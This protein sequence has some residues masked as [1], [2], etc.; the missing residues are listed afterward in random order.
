MCGYVRVCTVVVRDSYGSGAGF[1]REWCGIRTGES[2]DPRL[3]GLVIGTG[4]KQNLFKGN[5]RV[6]QNLL[7]VGSD[8][9]IKHP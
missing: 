9:A 2:R 5:G 4:L 7:K 6:K 1:V 8:S 3:G